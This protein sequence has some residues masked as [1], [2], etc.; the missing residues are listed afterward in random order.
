MEELLSKMHG[1]NIRDSA[2]AILHAQLV[3]VGRA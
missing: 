1:F 3:V 2:Y